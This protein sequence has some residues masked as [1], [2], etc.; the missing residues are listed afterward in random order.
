MDA[1]YQI[2]GCGAALA[3]SL[4]S[5]KGGGWVSE[6]KVGGGGRCFGPWRSTHAGSDWVQGN[7]LWPKML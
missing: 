5:R 2:A 7:K 4:E 3:G 6:G 1:V